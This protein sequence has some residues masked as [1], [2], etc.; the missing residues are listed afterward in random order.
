MEKFQHYSQA[1]PDKK[2]AMENLYLFGHPGI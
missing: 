2:K 1:H